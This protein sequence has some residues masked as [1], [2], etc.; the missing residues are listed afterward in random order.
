[1]TDQKYRLPACIDEMTHVYEHP[2]TYTVYH[3]ALEHSSYYKNY[4]VYANGLLVETS[5]IRYLKEL[6]NMELL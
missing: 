3:I 2:G 6:S 4:G 5:S 1:V